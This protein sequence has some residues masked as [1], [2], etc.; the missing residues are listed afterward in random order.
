MSK[1]QLPIFEEL[2]LADPEDSTAKPASKFAG[3][4]NPRH[5]RAI[6]SLMQ[7]ARFKNN[8]QSITGASNTP[9]LVAELRRRGLTIPCGRVPVLDRDGLV[10]RPGIYSFNDTDRRKIATWQRARGRA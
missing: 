9:E 8:L 3:T 1:G 7:R 2:A 4:D 6:H 10:T 5:L